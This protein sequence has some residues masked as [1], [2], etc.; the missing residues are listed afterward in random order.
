MN[1][2]ELA[3]IE[4]YCSGKLSAKE[5]EEFQAQYRDDP[6]FAEQVDLFAHAQDAIEALG[7]R[8]LKA[9]FRQKYQEEHKVVRPR[10]SKGYLLAAA[11]AVLLLIF[12]LYQNNSSSL[13]P[14][15]L[16]AEYGSFESLSFERD[17]NEADS[18][19]LAANAYYNEQKF[20]EAIPILE[21]LLQ[22][23]SFQRKEYALLHLGIS[24]MRNQEE[25]E[26]NKS[27]EQIL[28]QSSFYFQAQWNL[29]LNYLK[30]AQAEE[31]LPILQKLQ[32]ESRGY[33]K[34][35]EEIL[36]QLSP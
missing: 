30:Q 14:R 10:W 28:P 24:R 33:G 23:S 4:A 29:A 11:V 21:D 36:R 2:E 15:E 26:A 17:A 25:R 1:N 12:F 20:A 22:D 6:K 13:S 8:E 31:A 19:F 35:A 16:Y 7:Q 34:K 5:L 3:R 9:A 32:Q 27:L 18:L